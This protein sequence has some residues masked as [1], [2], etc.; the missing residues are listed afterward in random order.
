[1]PEVTFFHTGE[2]LGA[3]SLG[4]NLDTGVLWYADSTGKQR[5]VVGATISG[6]FTIDGALTVDGDT[7]VNGDLGVTGNETI[8]N[9]FSAPAAPTAV[10]D[11]TVGSVNAGTHDYALVW[12]T[13]AGSTTPSVVE[14]M[15]AAGSKSV[16]VGLDD[17][18]VPIGVTSISIYRTIANDDDGDLLLVVDDLTAEDFPYLDGAAD[19][20]LGALAPVVN[21]AGG[22][23][24]VEGDLAVTGTTTLTGDAAV[25]GAATITGAATI[26]G[27]LDHN[28]TTVG[29]YGKAPAVQG[30]HLSG[31]GITAAAIYAQLELMGV[32]AAS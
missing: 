25:G 10:E 27:A 2:P 14:N 22:N 5:L 7:T 21:D 24:T 1:M 3:N 32:F 30:S 4:L 15:T 28:G 11:D 26:G 18:T 16:L 9:A 23:L 8:D 29:F 17:Q 6:D 13:A 12:V 20:A 19:N 31:G